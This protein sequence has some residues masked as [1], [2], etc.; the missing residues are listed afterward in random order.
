MRRRQLLMAL[1]LGAL[2]APVLMGQA[3][4]GAPALNDLARGAGRLW[5]AAVSSAQ[6]DDPNLRRLLLAQVGLI[7]AENEMK[8]ETLQPQPGVFRFTAAD[9]LLDFAERHGLAMRGHTLVWH[10]QVPAWL[11]QLEGRALERAMATHIQTVM[12][13]YRGRLDSWDVVNEPIADDGTGLRSSFWLDQLGET[14]I[15]RALELAHAADPSAR[16]VINEYGLEGDAPKSARKRQR[17]LALLRDLRRRGVPLHAVGLQAHLHAHGGGPTTFDQLPAFLQA[18]ADL[19]LDILI[20]ELDVN[21]RDL[22][23]PVETRDQKVAAVYGAFLEA[24]LPQPRLKQLVSW[25]LSDRDTWLNSAFP[26]ADG[27]PQRPLPFDADLRRKAATGVI[28]QSLRRS[29]G[30]P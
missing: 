20:T 11:R 24:V 25:G 10:R 12:G 14:Y 17:F 1:A 30:T 18:I 21:D 8:W 26:R 2:S 28:E 15:A 7:V 13:R 29:S 22:A 9:R 19:D 23:A 3:G 27:Q 16:L 6:L 5:G 4:S